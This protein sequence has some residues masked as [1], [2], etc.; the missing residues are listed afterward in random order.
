MVL[1]E[2]G[3]LQPQALWLVR[4]WGRVPQC[5]IWRRQCPC[6][7]HKPYRMQSTTDSIAS[8]FDS[9]VEPR[10]CMLT[11][12]TTSS[13]R[14]STSLTLNIPKALS[15]LSP[16]TATVAENGEKTA[17]VAEFGDSRTFLRNR[18]QWAITEPKSINPSYPIRSQRVSD[19]RTYK[20]SVLLLIGL[21]IR[22]AK[23]Q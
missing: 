6:W 18:R 23:Y 11:S 20:Y 19:Q 22:P 17:T 5:H 3:G 8:F 12:L 14:F 16:K 7:T 9:T 13:P 1:P 21:C 10:S 4:L 2:S 15:T